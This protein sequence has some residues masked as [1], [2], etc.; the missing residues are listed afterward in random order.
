MS[1][2]T[3]AEAV[4]RLA[5]TLDHP[6]YHVDPYQVAATLR[7]LLAER[8]AARQAL[9]LVREMLHRAG[10]G[11]YED[12]YRAIFKSNERSV[13]AWNAMDAALGGTTHE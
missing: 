3:S 8:D 2:D 1:V 13:A 6:A 4:E 11:D 7:A 5:D 9:G 10:Q 12:G